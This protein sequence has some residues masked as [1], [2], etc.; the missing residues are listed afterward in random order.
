MK[1]QWLSG[2][3][4]CFHTTGSISYPRAGQGQFSLSSFLQWVDKL[5]QSLLG[6]FNTGGVSLQTNH[7][8]GTST[9]APQR[10]MVMYTGMSTVGPGPYGLLHH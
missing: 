7:L 3:V 1:A 4:S 9:H 6:D 8:I 5:V 10:P 2:S